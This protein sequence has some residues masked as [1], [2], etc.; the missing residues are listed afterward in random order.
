MHFTLP[1]LFSSI[2]FFMASEIK[3]KFKWKIV[4]TFFV[5]FGSLTLFEIGEYSLDTYL[6]FRLQGIYL[7]DLQGNFEIAQDK[8]DDTMIDLSLGGLGAITYLITAILYYAKS[9]N[10][11]E[12]S[13]REFE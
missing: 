6:G 13:K 8:I 3:M 11:L 4:F 5:V 12:T 2:I 10:N 9:G 7:Y 1:I